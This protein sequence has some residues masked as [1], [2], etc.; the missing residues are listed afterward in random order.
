[1]PG[2]GINKILY[3]PTFMYTQM[4]NLLQSYN[5]TSNQSVIQMNHSINCPLFYQ[6]SWLFPCCIS[7]MSCLHLV[8][9]F[10]ECFFFIELKHAHA[11]SFAY[12]VL[13]REFEQLSKPMQFHSNSEEEINL[14]YQTTHNDFLYIFMQAFNTA[15]LGGW[16]LRGIV[17]PDPL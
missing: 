17:K 14:K 11:Q 9:D 12:H 1:M 16:K 6:Q 15:G 3:Q 7:F 10:I 4:Q 5:Q 2:L 13:Y 8:L